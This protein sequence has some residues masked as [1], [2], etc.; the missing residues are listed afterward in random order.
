MQTARG[1]IGFARELAACVQGAQ[2]HF[3]RGFV[4][5]LW[6]RINRDAAP[7][8][9]DGHGI[10]GVQFNLDPV[11]VARDGLVHRVVQNFGDQMVQ[12]A[13]V[14][15]ADIHAGAFA[16]R[17]QALPAP[18]CCRRYSRQGRC[19]TKDRW[20]WAAH[21]NYCLVQ[22]DRAGGV[23]EG[24]NQALHPLGSKVG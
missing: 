12:R 23:G 9:A 10:I 3:E 24:C 6:V 18:R 8:V 15:A 7:V 17:F 11:G 5:K 21:L 19:W 22:Y 4:G 14:G 1:L 16:H 13:F 2:D 20:S